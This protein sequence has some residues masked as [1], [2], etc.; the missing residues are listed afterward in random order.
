LDSTQTSREDVPEMQKP[1]LEPKERGKNMNKKTFALIYVLMISTGFLAGLSV[2]EY[3]T[4]VINRYS[5]VVEVFQIGNEYVA[6]ITSGFFVKDVYLCKTDYR[7]SY[8]ETRTLSQG[9]NASQVIQAAID[10][11]GFIFFHAGIYNLTSTLWIGSNT[12]LMGD[13]NWTAVFTKDKFYIK[14]D[15][16]YVIITGLNA[17][18]P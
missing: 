10:H 14:P 1:K 5:G 2:L 3:H 11:A 8:I 9:T 13:Y 6:N 12:T 17:T 15:A 18:M 4:T 16:T 7:E